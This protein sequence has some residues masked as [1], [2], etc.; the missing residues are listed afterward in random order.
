MQP[1][2]LV[3]VIGPSGSGK[4][5]FLNCIAGRNVKGVAGDILFN[6]VPR[7]GNFAR[8]TGYV[9]QG[10]FG[11]DYYPLW[12]VCCVLSENGFPHKGNKIG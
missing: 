11:S 6:D 8:F 2:E 1:G 5:S 3:A 4:S 12:P 10:M 9:I 7:P